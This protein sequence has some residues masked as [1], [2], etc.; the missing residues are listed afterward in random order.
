MVA[1]AR[2]Y[3]RSEYQPQPEHSGVA[4]I[5][6]GDHHGTG[7]LL[8]DGRAVLTAAH[9]WD[10]APQ[11]LPA[12]SIKIEFHFSNGDKQ[13]LSAESYALYPGYRKN[14]S[15]QQDLALVWLSEPAST[16]AW[17]YTLYRDDPVGQ[18]FNLVGYGYPGTGQQGYQPSNRTSEITKLSAW[19]LFDLDASLLSQQLENITGSSIQPGTQLVADFDNGRPENDALGQ[20]YNT[21][22]LGL[23]WKEGMITPGDSGG[24]AFIDGQVAGIASY[25][26][27][28]SSP[29][30]SPDIDGQ[31]NGTFGELGFWTN[32]H[33]APYQQWIDQTLRANYQNAPARRED[34]QTEWH[35]QPNEQALT[36]FLLEYLGTRTPTSDQLLFH[37]STRDGSAQAGI[38]YLPQQGSVILYPEENQVAIP[39]T[40]MGRDQPAQDLNFY[41][42]VTHETAGGQLVE[43]S[44]QRL[45]Q[46]DDWLA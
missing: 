10:A 15:H 22:D 33:H 19:N 2:N 14:Q 21:P 44:A 32:T 30:G 41:L 16:D 35:L 4:R 6:V 42:D 28:L 23:G 13:T 45:I 36:Y 9:L 37:F 7:S 31:L 24:P 1:T 46:V 29:Q 26:A 5:N 43:L 11:Q 12:E 8:Y 25:S 27:R 20:L 40:L 34:V 39:I 17:R 38:D 18:V 3:T